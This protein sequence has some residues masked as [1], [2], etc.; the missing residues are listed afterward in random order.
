V[1][2][3]GQG[4]TNLVE[5]VAYLA[6]LSSHRAATAAP[7]VRRGAASAHIRAKAVRGDRSVRVEVEIAPGKA[8]RARLGKAKVRPSALLGVVKAVAFVPEDVGLVKGGPELRRRYLDELLVQLRPSLAGVIADYERVSRQRTALLRSM[9]ELTGGER[10]AAEAGLDVW[11]QRAAEL[12]GRLT[13]DRMA[14]AADLAPAVAEAYGQ[15]ADGAEASL[16]YVPSVD[17]PRRPTADQATA[18]LAAALLEGRRRE[19]QR[20]AAL[21]GPQRED[22]AFGI[23]GTAARGYASHGESWSLALAARVGAYRLI[24]QDAGDA[25]VLILDDVFA[26]LDTPRREALAALVAEAEQV[27]VTAAVR[28]DVPDGLGASWR[29]VRD[30]TVVREDAAGA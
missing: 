16:E 24:E 7:L 14:L 19:V 26:E 5:A 6:T 18:A 3:N 2:G 8:A 22:L 1:G 10:Q 20:G 9:G 27:L 11:D 13:A 29:R 21:A 17:L 12:G 23:D 30:G 25:P 15:I 28:E 4:K